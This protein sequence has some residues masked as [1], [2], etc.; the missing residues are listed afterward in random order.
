VYLNRDLLPDD[1]SSIHHMSRL[2]FEGIFTSL[3]IP[4]DDPASYRKRLWNL[5]DIAKRE[6]LSLMIDVSGRALE[7]VGLSVNDPSSIKKKGISG[8]RIDGGLSMKSVAALS[9]FITIALN[10][11]TLSEE[12]YRA[13]NKYHADFT[14][15]EAWH[16]YYPRPET[17]LDSSWLRT[18]N[19]WLKEKGMTVAA[20]A[21]G[22]SELR[23]PI[24][25]T[26]PTLE[27]HRYLNPL[28]AALSLIMHSQTDRVYIGDPHLTKHT[29]KQFSMY[30]QD[31][32]I[33]LQG[34]AVD[35]K[36]SSSIFRKHVNR[37]DPARDVIRSRYSR[38]VNRMM[39]ITAENTSARNR[40][41][42]TIDND[43]YGRYKGEIQIVKHPLPPDS[44][45]NVIGHIS[46]RDLPLIDFIE[47]GT[48]FIVEGKSYDVRKIND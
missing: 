17:G 44:K 47:Q 42:I 37:P 41:T 22:D 28:A 29:Q 30:I 8:L 26:L 15:I 33:L 27:A 6:K 18:R 38:S 1:E 13:L 43:Q 23:G 31:K 24:Y 3:Q 10:A 11:S 5:M 9:H 12:D 45:V 20:F 2:G 16:N 34:K 48:E 14:H 21:P 19:R 35:E 32:A 40:G 4:E 36:W 25:R 7:T 39:E 46:S